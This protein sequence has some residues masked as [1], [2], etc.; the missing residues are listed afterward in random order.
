MEVSMVNTLRNVRLLGT[1]L[2][3]VLASTAP[4]TAQFATRTADT[5]VVQVENRNFLDVRVYAVSGSL[6]WR[7]GN[8]TGMTQAVFTLPEW[9]TGSG[10]SVQMLAYPVGQRS[11]ATSQA[12]LV[13]PGDQIVFRIE[14]HLA[15]SNAL[16]RPGT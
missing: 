2:I 1:A 11:V 8:V 16:R 4:A 15:L 12:L 5:V 13:N 7:L 10:E 14:Q 9:M 3:A 6:V